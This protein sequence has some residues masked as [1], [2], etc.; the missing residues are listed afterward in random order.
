VTGIKG[1]AV[2]DTDVASFMLKGLPL[3]AEYTELVCGYDLHLSFATAGNYIS[4]T[5]G[6][7]AACRGQ[8]ESMS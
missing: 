1:T 4:S 3:G 7:A 2:L 5:C 6:A 8:A